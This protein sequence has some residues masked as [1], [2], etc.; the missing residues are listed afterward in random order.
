MADMAI[1]RFGGPSVYLLAASRVS[2]S[3]QFAI[4]SAAEGLRVSESS[5]FVQG[6]GNA[7]F[8]GCGVAAVQ[9]EIGSS[10]SLGGGTTQSSYIVANTEGVRLSFGA[11]GILGG[12]WSLINS[13]GI[14]ATDAAYCTVGF[15]SRNFSS[16]EGS[17]DIFAANR[18]SVI[19]ARNGGTIVI[20]SPANNTVGNNQAYI[21][22]S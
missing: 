6:I 12:V 17:V 9:A 14:I 20:F 4:G 3:G 19:G 8:N 22:V 21:A 5:S 1:I 7:F 16:A 2:C 15:A 18:A 11:V 10:V 13:S